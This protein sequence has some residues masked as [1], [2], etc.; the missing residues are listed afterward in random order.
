MSYLELALTSSILASGLSNTKILDC[1]KRCVVHSFDY[2]DVTTEQNIR[3][4]FYLKQ[5]NGAAMVADLRAVGES[6][7]GGSARDASSQQLQ[8]GNFHGGTAWSPQ[9]GAD[10]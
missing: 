7:T 2:F 3:R 8:R 9:K 4:V 5:N 6:P 1:H 10:S